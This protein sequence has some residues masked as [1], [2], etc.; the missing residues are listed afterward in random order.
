MWGQLREWS[1]GGVYWEGYSSLSDGGP[2]CTGQLSW[3]YRW[4]SSVVTMGW[5]GMLFYLVARP[6]ANLVLKRLPEGISPTKLEL[7]TGL[8]L[9]LCSLLQFTY[10]ILGKRLIF[11][12]SPCHLVCIMQ[13]LL[14]VLPTS[15]FSYWLFLTMS[16]WMYGP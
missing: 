7:F 4:A 15:G 3:E 1:L 8:L 16:A 6:R 11:M 12:L 2:D 9:L 5:Y 10:K 13:L 14:C